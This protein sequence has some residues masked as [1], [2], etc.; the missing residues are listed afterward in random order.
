MDFKEIRVLADLE[1]KVS[2][3]V[4]LMLHTERR[5]NGAP[6]NL[7]KNETYGGLNLAD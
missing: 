1:D 6:R 7:I 4:S 3:D 5:F 2:Q